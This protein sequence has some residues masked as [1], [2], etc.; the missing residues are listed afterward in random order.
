MTLNPSQLT[1][2]RA[3]KIIE[4]IEAGVFPTRAAQA[5]GVSK[6]TWANWL[7]RGRGFDQFVDFI[8]ALPDEGAKRMARDRLL[9]KEA[10]ASRQ[11]CVDALT[12]DEARYREL[13]ERVEAAK[14][15][16]EVTAVLLLRELAKKGDSKA[17]TFYLERAHRERWGRHDR[18]SIESLTPDQLLA[19]AERLEKQAAEDDE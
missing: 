10:D 19:E 8:S 2:E 18:I 16:G 7:K 5:T 4:Y 17:V 11:E 14:A 15:L 12:S 6:R 3:D 1:P 13:Y 9:V